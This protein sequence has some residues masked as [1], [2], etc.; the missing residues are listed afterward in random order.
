MLYIKFLLLLLLFENDNEIFY[1]SYSSKIPANGL[2][3][4]LETS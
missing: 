2:I 1:I 3:I 4:A